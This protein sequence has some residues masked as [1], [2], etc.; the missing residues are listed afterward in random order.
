MTKH[1]IIGQ[2]IVNAVL[3]IAVAIINGLSGAAV[4]GFKSP[5]DIS[6]S[7]TSWLTPAGFA[8]AIWGVIYLL[9]AIFTVYQLLPS[10]YDDDIITRDCM[11]LPFNYIG[12][13]AWIFVW[14]ETMFTFAFMVLSF[15]TIVLLRV[16]VLVTRRNNDAET[17]TSWK[18]VFIVEL[19]I[20]TYLGWITAASFANLYAIGNKPV[21]GND[22]I[23]AVAGLVFIFLVESGIA[24]YGRNPMP[25]L[26]GILLIMH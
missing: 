24:V 6:D 18:D 3:F 22:L 19:P 9:L 26:V 2:R 7:N 14:N 25:T 12:N 10:T 23:E 5:G 17:R 21:P 1:S 15:M 4:A 16:Y 11:L 20:S 8:F 13:I